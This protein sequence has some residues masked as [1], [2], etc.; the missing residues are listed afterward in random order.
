MNNFG[1]ELP[2]YR[3]ITIGNRPINIIINITKMEILVR[4]Q[5]ENDFLVCFKKE[6]K[7]EKARHGFSD[8]FALFN[9]S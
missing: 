6:K 8:E 4:S 3:F 2:L 7:M 1:K 5:F 9:W